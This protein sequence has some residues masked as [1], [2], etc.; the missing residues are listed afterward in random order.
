M[1]SYVTAGC[2]EL[3][4]SYFELLN[5]IVIILFIPLLNN[6]LLPCVPGASI[7]R[8]V[9]VGVFFFLL[10]TVVGTVIFWRANTTDLSTPLLWLTIPILVMS[11][12][13][14]LV[15]ISGKKH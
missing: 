6:V 2:S 1:Y 7:K 10:S 13:D 4:G 14:A 15:F 9:G 5:N 12:G 3:K 8:R 11:L